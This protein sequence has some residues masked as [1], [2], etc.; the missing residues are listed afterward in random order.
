MF[1]VREVFIPIEWHKDRWRS[2]RRVLEGCKRDAKK[3]VRDYLR[4]G[5]ART[6]EKA[7]FGG[8]DLVNCC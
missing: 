7:E 2:L 1:K 4:Q 3:R 8:Q 6:T 5:S